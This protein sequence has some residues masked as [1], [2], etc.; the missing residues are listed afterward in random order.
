MQVQLQTSRYTLG[1][2]R[3][4]LHVRFQVQSD[5]YAFVGAFFLSVVRRQNLRHDRSFQV[6]AAA[7]VRKLSF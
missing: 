3:A 4:L 7:A 2:L 1:M 6:G 5:G